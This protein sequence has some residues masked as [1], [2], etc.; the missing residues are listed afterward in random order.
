MKVEEDP[1]AEL[2][3]KRGPEYETLTALGSLL[4]NDRLDVTIKANSL[5]NITA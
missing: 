4:L 2:E 3:L 1:Y 5:C